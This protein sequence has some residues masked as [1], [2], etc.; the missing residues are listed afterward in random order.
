MELTEFS[1]SINII[2]YLP[3][4]TGQIG[5]LGKSMLVTMCLE[6][7]PSLMAQRTTLDNCF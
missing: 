1:T 5:N 7:T 6:T 4:A 2:H 3:I